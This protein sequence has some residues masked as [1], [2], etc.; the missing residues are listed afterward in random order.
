MVEKL[1]YTNSP[2]DDKYLNI[3]KEEIVAIHKEIEKV[4]KELERFGVQPTCNKKEKAEIQQP[5]LFG[6]CFPEDEDL[7]KIG[8]YPAKDLQLIFL[9]K[10]KRKCVHKDLISAFVRKYKPNAALDQQTRHL[11]TQ[12]H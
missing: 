11:G 2:L 7:K 5:S 3:P 1:D 4:S 6:N 12:L 10:Y 9:Y 8:E